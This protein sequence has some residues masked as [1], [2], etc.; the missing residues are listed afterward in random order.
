MKFNDRQGAI[1]I[2]SAPWMDGEYLTASGM[3]EIDK[4]RGFYRL[5]A[6]NFQNFS[7]E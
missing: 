3:G 6:F 4:V 5:E 2:R 1:K 7:I